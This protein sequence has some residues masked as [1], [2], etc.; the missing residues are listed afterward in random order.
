VAEELTAAESFPNLLHD[1]F[2][3]YVIQTLL[4]VG[5]DDLVAMIV[6]KIQP[7]LQ[8][9]R[10]TL[11]GKRIQVGRDN[12]PSS[13]PHQLPPKIQPH[14]LDTPRKADLS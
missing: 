7:H 12:P 9:L 2:A 8:T 3:N 10:S 1:P 13:L 14:L 11:Y 6:A 5:P 4:T